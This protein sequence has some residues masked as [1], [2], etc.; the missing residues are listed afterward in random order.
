MG[1]RKKPAPAG[2]PCKQPA[3]A[4]PARKKPTPA[5]PSATPPARKKPATP[6]PAK[7]PVPPRQPRRGSTPPPAPASGD[8][9]RPP[10]KKPAAKKPPAS[11]L[12]PHASASYDAHKDRS[13]QR[14]A[15]LSRTGRDIGPIPAVADPA[16]RAASLADFELFC[17]TYFPHTFQLDFCDD[18]RRAIRKIE[19]AVKTGRLF[20]FS[21]P[22]GFGKTSLCESSAIWAALQ[23]SRRF[24]ALIGASAAAAAEMLDSIKAEL[25]SNELL[26]AD[27]PEACYPIVRIEGLANRCHGQLCQGE[28]THISWTSTKI[29]LPTIPG[30]QASGAIIRVAGITGRIRGMKHKLQDGEPLRPD[31]VIV[32]D[33]QTDDSAGSPPQCAKRI[34]V[35]SGSI[36]GLAGPGK[37]IAGFMPCTVICRDDMAD[38]I[39]DRARHPEWQGERS[40]LVYTF[41]SNEP[42]WDEYAKIRSESL[43]N[44]GDGSP[45]TEFYRDNRLA[46][47][48]GARIAWPARCNADELSAIQNA[49]NLRLRNEAAF[50][51]EYQNEPLDEA[52]LSATLP[53]AVELLKKTNGLSRGVV[54]SIA[55]HLTAFIDVQGELLYWY[56]CAWW[57]GFGGA[58][59]DYG[60]WPTQPQAY[61]TLNQ[62]KQTLSLAYPGRD[63]LGRIFAGLKDLTA[64]M[65]PHE[66]KTSGGTG[67][68]IERC[69]IDA[70]W[71]T[72][73]Q[74]VKEF[75][76][77]SPH[78]AVLIPSHGKYIGAATTPFHMYKR[79][80]GERL[81][82][83]WLI[84]ATGRHDVR[85]VLVDVNYWKSLCAS[86]LVLAAGERGSWTLFGG[87]KTD[88]RMLADHLT[89]EAY[90]RTEGRGRT[91]DEWKLKPGQSENHWWDGLV[92]CA[93]AASIAGVVATELASAPISH[94]KPLPGSKPAG[95]RLSFADRKA[96]ARAKG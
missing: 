87:P 7:P 78:A 5:K 37:K 61:F 90:I 74:T 88:H 4:K 85:H 3:P 59:I 27:F 17:R 45:A 58:T 22:R 28:R 49:M 12:K 91:V 36:L 82:L 83:H 76:R 24:V 41:P 53:V 25:E 72:S 43:R 20:A 6:P 13:R 70:S 64:R 52:Q 89:S 93:A 31:L 95:E 50:W 48:E 71:G 96:R 55:T 46:M 73:T 80:P 21:M 44:D 1:K 15:T 11:P 40:K 14:Q 8:G 67:L 18:H 34:R 56:V 79:K 86:R 57:P 92:G 38:E 66:W 54:P 16:R 29:V 51:A 10:A 60:T 84:P 39:L 26:A 65:L 81:G 19:L 42:L 75:C 68:R 2:R 62:A 77:Q 63:Q 9:V 94:Q 69:L 33:P 47:D 23:G 32:D 35:L 30:S